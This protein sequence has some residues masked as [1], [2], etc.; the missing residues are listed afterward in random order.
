MRVVVWMAA[1]IACFVCPNALE[2]QVPRA[3]TFGVSF[4]VPE[5]GGAGL[6]LRY[7][8]SDNLNMG[9][10]FD[11]DV[12]YEPASDDGTQPGQESRTDWS[13]GF[14]PDFRFYQG[15]GNPVAPFFELGLGVTYAKLSEGDLS[16]LVVRGSV[17]VGAEWFPTQSVGISGATGVETIFVHS[18][19][20]G[21]PE[22]TA[23]EVSVGVF[24][25]ELTL[26]LYF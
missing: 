4:D 12:S 11:F 8:P 21:E 20:G 24:R 16:D 15:A 22:T 6:G 3:G 19:L 7:L 2:A 14:S 23:D 26:N 9:I 13:L 18:K 17:G 10:N 25:S 1:L 5:G